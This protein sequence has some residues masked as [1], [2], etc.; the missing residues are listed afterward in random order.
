MWRLSWATGKVVAS[1]HPLLKAVLA[2][3]ETRAGDAVELLVNRLGDLAGRSVAVLGAAFEGGTDD[4]RAS[5]GLRLVDSLLALDVSTVI[6]D[7]LVPA[8]SLAEYVAAERGW[9][10]VWLTLWR[11]PMP[12]SSRRTRPSLR[13]WQRSGARRAVPNTSCRRSAVPRPV[14]LRRLYRAVGRGRV[15]SILATGGRAFE[16]CDSGGWVRHA[17]RRRERSQTETDGGDR[18]SADPGTS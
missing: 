1:D 5:P 4:V 13:P 8:A 9:R 16:S 11:P 7:P 3:N 12:A 15:R 14:G 10:A 2:V 18:R 6:F 17:D